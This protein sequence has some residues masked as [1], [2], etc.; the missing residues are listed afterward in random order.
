MVEKIIMG[1][2]AV[3]LFLG[4]GAFGQVQVKN[5]AMKRVLVFRPNQDAI[6]GLLAEIRDESIVVLTSEREVT[7]PFSEI[8]RILRTYERGRVR[9]PIYGAILGGYAGAYWYTSSS[10]NGGFVESGFP[11]GYLLVVPSSIAI[12]LGIGYLVELG[13]SQKDEVFDFTGS[14][15]A[16]AR[17]RSRLT[18]AATHEPRESNVHITIQGSHV[19]ASMPELNPGG[20][21]D[22]YGGNRISRFKLLRKAQVTYSPA[23]DI[24][25][26]VALVWFGDPPQSSYGYENFA[27][28]DSKHYQGTQS[29]E[30]LGKCVVVLYNPLYHVMESR[31]VLKVGGGVGTASIDYTRTTSAWSYIQDGVGSQQNS[32][33]SVSENVVV[34]YLFGQ[35]EYEAVDGL[36]IGLVLDKV[37]GPSRDAP[38]VPEANIPAQTLDFG[39]S[40]VGFTISV[41]F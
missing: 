19:H 25:A 17:E 16:K 33:F 22:Y 12:G 40:S 2:L 10:D 26:G 41:H 8:S 35:V 38:A 3:S 28:G 5:P 31:F 13:S 27:N 24:E 6:R 36:S 23:P 21:T 4:Q 34:G 14:D 18:D 11:L 29:F 7:V 32:L 20:S 37:F 30:A 15:S 39:S 1:G 9:G